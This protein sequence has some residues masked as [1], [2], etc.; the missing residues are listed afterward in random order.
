MQEIFFI[1]LGPSL[2]VKGEYS[3]SEGCEFESHRLILNG[4]FLH[5]FVVKFVLSVWKRPKINEKEVEDGPFKKQIFR[6]NLNR[7]FFSGFINWKN[8]QMSIKVAQ[9]WFH[10]E[11][12]RFWHL[13]KNCLKMREIWANQLLPKAIKSC[14]FPKNR[15]IRSHW[16]RC[17]IYC[18]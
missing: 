2:V 18:T 16:S 4:H 11:N 5:W 14:P 15:P 6:Q 12:N 7:N 8:C 1:G 9:K 17:K 10:K 13:Y 3:W